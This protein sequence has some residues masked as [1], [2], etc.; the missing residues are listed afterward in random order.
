MISLLQPAKRSSNSSE[1]DASVSKKSSESNVVLLGSDSEN[2]E[3]KKLV[4]KK[5]LQLKKAPTK[6]GPKKGPQPDE[7]QT[8]ITAAFGAAAKGKPISKR[9]PDRSSEEKE[10]GN[11]EQ[12][13][14]TVESKVWAKKLGTCS[15]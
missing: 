5:K 9:K 7:K 4:P 13:L 3:Q 6:R 8:T 1:S 2:E 12:D 10:E 14:S 15:S 11:D